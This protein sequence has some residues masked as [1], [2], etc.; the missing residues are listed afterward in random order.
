VMS[1]TVPKVPLVPSWA[2][3][4][5]ST[6]HRTS[7]RSGLIFSQCVSQV[8][9]CLYILGLEFCTCFSFLLYVLYFRQSRPPSR[10]VLPGLW[11]LR[12]YKANSFYLIKYCFNMVMI[13]YW[14]SFKA[15]CWCFK[16]IA[17]PALC[18]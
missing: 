5:L 14:K 4:V 16:A 10:F 9:F 15:C 6:S 8:N 3:Y 18:I 2:R 1:G 17:I 13:F 11:S 12:N 7:W